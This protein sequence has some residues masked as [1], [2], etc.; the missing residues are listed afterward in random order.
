MTAKNVA[1]V[2]ATTAT[3]T[4]GGKLWEGV[5]TQSWKARIRGSVPAS[6]GPWGAQRAEQLQ[7]VKRK[8]K[9]R[10]RERSATV[11]GASA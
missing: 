7:E 4:R 3:E 6:K 9:Q 11:D 10:P 2:R 8:K 1:A 5:S